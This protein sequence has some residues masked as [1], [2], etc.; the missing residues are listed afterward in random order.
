LTVN[1]NIP[2]YLKLHVE[3]VPGGDA[4]TAA[5]LSTLDAVCSAFQRA[6][7]WPLRYV[8]RAERRSAV[9]PRSADP[10]SHS[11][12]AAAP[13]LVI[14]EATVEAQP[15][16]SA[17]LP[18]RID[19]E[20]VKPLVSAL[21]EL[22][23]Q[24]EHTRHT[25]WQREAEL[26]AGVP[27]V[28]D[29][30]EAAHLAVRLEA[31]L[32]GGAEAVGC[33]AAALYLLDDATSVLKLRACWNLPEDRFLLPPR[34]LRGAVADL[35]ALVGHAVVLEDTR[36]L[37]HWRTPED[38][39]SALC[40]PVSTPTVPLGTLWVFSDR[41]RDF[42]AEQTN[43][44]EIVAGRLA[45]DLEREMLLHE[46]S[47]SK[48]VK[49]HLDHAA[50]WQQ[51][52]RPTISPQ[53]DDWQL[54]GWTSPGQYLSSGFYDWSVLPDGRLAA[55]VGGAEGT[56]I[57]A[58]LTAATLHSAVKSHAAY[59]HDVRR[60]LARVNQTLWTTSTGG[61]LASLFYALIDPAT[62][63]IEYASAGPLGA[64]LLRA[65][66]C[67]V[68]ARPTL[69][70]GMQP[71]NRY[72]LYRGKLHPSDAL[73][74]ASRDVLE[75]RDVEGRRLVQAAATS[76]LRECRNA[77]AEQLVDRLEILLASHRPH[78]QRIDQTL[79]VVRRRS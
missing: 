25:L 39:P 28:A 9:P 47:Q 38:F 51:D 44:V 5:P 16:E 65:K 8:P 66:S 23:S 13:C 3:A 76:A 79:L 58:A 2:S 24:F 75:A 53:L 21:C 4:R 29:G 62:G 46:G 42:T 32:R 30:D 12:E 37:P 17:E 41:G 57:E 35:E 60:M 64:F 45:S 18:P 19:R 69:P 20:R 22:L 72:K 74:I 73:I 34:P 40:V 63:S 43:L 31:V 70:L 14:D 27:V 50:R 6:T 67:A 10:A 15:S 54:A 1:K 49:R 7:G 71:D 52:R 11:A 77:T 48:V 33:Q 68:I 26:A 59:R 56:M 78:E 61:Q 55:L 36:L